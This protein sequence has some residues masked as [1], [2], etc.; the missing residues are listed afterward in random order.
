MYK[1]ICTSIYTYIY[2]Y[3][4][5]YIYIYIYIC[6]PFCESP[7]RPDPVWKPAICLSPLRIP[8]H[9]ASFPKFNLLPINSYGKIMGMK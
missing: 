1:Y 9:T 2:I 6:I 7:A 8:G 5:I 4:Y 3:A